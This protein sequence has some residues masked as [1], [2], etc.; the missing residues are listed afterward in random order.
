MAS[1]SETIEIIFGATD[2]TSRVIT[3]IGRNL[4]SLNNQVSDV[5]QPL[6]TLAGSLLKTETALVALAAAYGGFSI[7]KALDFKDA[8]GNLAKVLD[9]TDPSVTSFTDNV[10]K[11]SEK[12]GIAATAVLNGMADFKQAGFDAKDAAVLEKQALDLT[13]AGD[14][15][16]GKASE[17]LIASIKGFGA[18]ASA[19]PRY[20]EALNNVSNHYATSLSTL[21]DGMVAISPIASKMGFSFEETTGLLTPIIEVFRSGPEAANALKTGLL[22]LIDKSKPVGDALNS[23]GVSQLDVNGKM[24]DGK[25][26]FIDV[27]KAFKGLDKKQKL[28]IAS[29]ITGVDQAGKMVI[30]FDSLKKSQDITAVALKATG[31]RWVRNSFLGLTIQ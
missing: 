28:V 24:R 3:G 23:I 18:Q 19:A 21:A 25:S 10:I 11:L 30:A 8:Q 6:D 14:V 22:K 4:H 15:D 29:Q 27:A 9:A 20:I 31:S 17:I 12:Y 7:Q 2:N 5:T 13:V 16:I 26:I 1:I